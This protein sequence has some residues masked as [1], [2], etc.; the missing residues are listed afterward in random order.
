MS[1]PSDVDWSQWLALVQASVRT[2]WRSGRTVQGFGS[3]G[4]RAWA[5]VASVL[6][7]KLLVGGTLAVLIAVSPDRF[8]ST[9][10]YFTLVIFAV[11]SSVVLDFPTIVISP[12]DHEM[13]AHL[14]VSSQTFFL[15]RISR[16]LLYVAV[17]TAPLALLPCLSLTT[18][19]GL[20]IAR[21]AVAVVATGGA[22]FGTAVAI[23]VLYTAIQQ[24]VP[25]A[26]QR[27]ALTTLQFGLGLA[28]Y[29]SVV[30]VPA[31]LGD[32]MR[33]GLTVGK[34]WWLMLNPASWFA[35]WIEI[36][37]GRAGWL[38]GLSAVVSA[39]AL[40]A[41]VVVVRGRMSLEYADSLSIAGPAG[42]PGSGFSR[43]PGAP[44]RIAVSLLPA[45]F[46]HHEGRAIAL[47]VRAQFRFDP[48]FRLA[49]LGIAPLTVVYLI[50]GVIMD[51]EESGAAHL[52]RP[53]LYHFATMLF[54]VMLQQSLIRSDAHQAAWVY[55]A[56]PTSA[57]RLLL[58][59]KDLVFGCFVLPYLAVVGVAVWAFSGDTM[60]L[61][62]GLVTMALA[63]HAFLLAALWMDPRLPFSIPSRRPVEGR[64]LM[65]IMLATA[66]VGQAIAPALDAMRASLA[67]AVGIL[68][69]LT[70]T[71]LAIRRVLLTR[72][73][74]LERRGGYDV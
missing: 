44:S 27:P 60:S 71:N 61:G 42:Q 16:L 51:A 53:R 65:G 63:S 70:V 57:A 19:G 4:G 37:E 25:R 13:L 74:S 54:P 40:V 21:G 33:K 12:E 22:A 20:S 34:P 72:V 29:G 39:V 43:V 7:L 58:A 26:W 3:R 17:L 66:A 32:F 15:A 35:S 11:A 46:L 9:T 8:L 55:R 50:A 38:D 59:L 36:V 2:D 73:A 41:G 45:R 10:L 68:I 5:F 67:V 28:L 49:V 1:Q 56:T 69:G 62:L 52:G 64:A 14:P 48:R 31:L 47:L 24:S 18:A 6:V 23:V 30:A